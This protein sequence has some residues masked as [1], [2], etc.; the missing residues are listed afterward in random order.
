M[1]NET[2]LSIL[3]GKMADYQADYR[4]WDTAYKEGDGRLR[5]KFKDMINDLVEWEVVD[6]DQEIAISAYKAAGYSMDTKVR[7]DFHLCFA[8]AIDMT[9]GK[10]S[11]GREQAMQ[12]VLEGQVGY[13]K[14]M[15]D[16][17]RDANELVNEGKIKAAK[18]EWLQKFRKRHF[19][20][21]LDIVRDNYDTLSYDDVV[22]AFQK[23]VETRKADD[24]IVIA[25]NKAKDAKRRAAGGK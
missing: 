22:E 25:A 5:R 19:R 16:D 7:K 13:G 3:N 23:Y 10:T 21:M 6:G 1:I 11:S 17:L 14:R 20:P 2:R 15:V 9:N 18:W 24:A 12:R 8:G 4:A